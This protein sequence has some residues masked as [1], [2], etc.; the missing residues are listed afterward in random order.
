MA[1]RWEKRLQRYED[2]ERPFVYL[3]DVLVALH[4]RKEELVEI[5]EKSFLGHLGIVPN[6]DMTR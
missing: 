2:L 5:L 6:L 1:Y 3:Q 4:S